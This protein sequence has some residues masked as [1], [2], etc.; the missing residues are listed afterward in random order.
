MTERKRVDHYQTLNLAYEKN[1][2]LKVL[3]LAAI[4]RVMKRQASRISW[5]RARDASTKLFHAKMRSRRRKNFIHAL[6]V[7]NRVL[8]DHKAKEQSIYDHFSGSLG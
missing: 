8:V 2:K 6:N 7:N 1:L 5:L 4:E 3:G